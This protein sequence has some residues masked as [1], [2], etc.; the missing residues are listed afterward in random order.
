ESTL[1]QMR[2][3]AGSVRLVS[4]VRLGDELSKLLLGAQPAQALRLAGDTGVLT[5]LLPE[6]EP[7]LREHTFTVVQASADEGASLAVRLAA[8]LHDVGKPSAPLPEHAARG[9]ELADR[10]LER[11]RYP[12]RLR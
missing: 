2:D 7:A 6:L 4:G 12:T 8:L 5:A 9:A 10:A 3:E 11:L 1:Q